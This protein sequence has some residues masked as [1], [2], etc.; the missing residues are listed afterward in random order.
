MTGFVIGP[1]TAPA[2]ELDVPVIDQTSN[3]PYMGVKSP[4]IVV[5]DIIVKQSV[6]TIKLENM[7]PYPHGDAENKQRLVLLWEMWG[8]GYPAPIF[9]GATMNEPS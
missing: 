9:F 5:G 3:P 2:V 4:N 6:E 7:M 1:L 8:L